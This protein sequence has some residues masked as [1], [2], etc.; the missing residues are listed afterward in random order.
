MGWWAIDT[1]NPN[2]WPAGSNYL[3]LTAADVLLTQEVRV[4]RG[5]ARLAAGQAARG[6]KWNL[7]IEPCNVAKGGGKSAGAAVAA[8]SFIGMSTS[9]AVTATQHLHQTGRFTMKRLAAMGKGGVRLGSVYL[10]S[11]V[12]VTAKRHLDL[13]CPKSLVPYGALKAHDDFGK[14][15]QRGETTP[16]RKKTF[17]V[18]N[19][20]VSCFEIWCVRGEVLPTVLR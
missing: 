12:G 7:A 13:A 5:H 1:V 17:S 19:I 14:N 11:T 20:N 3:A 2:A 4:T 18:K 8:R 10:H 9:K 16:K 6:I 15:H